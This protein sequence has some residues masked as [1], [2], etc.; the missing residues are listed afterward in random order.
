[1]LSIRQSQKSNSLH[2]LFFRMKNIKNNIFILGLFLWVITPLI[3]LVLLLIYSQIKIS[4]NSIEGGKKIVICFFPL[5]LIIF[6]LSTYIASFE[7]FGDTSIYLDIYYMLRGSDPYALPD[8]GMEPVSFILPKYLSQLTGGNQLS[9]LFVQSLTLNTAFTIYSIIFIPEFYPLV[10]LINIMTQGYYF[11]LFW[12]RQIYSYIFTIPAIYS[13]NIVISSALI[14]VSYF[15]HNSS[16]LFF[17]PT[18]TNFFTNNFT[19]K[20]RLISNKLN[21]SLNIFSKFI[22]IRIM[23]FIIFFLIVASSGFILR[24]SLEFLGSSSLVGETASDKINTYSGNSIADFNQNHFTIRSQLRN[25]LDFIIIFIFAINADYKKINKVFIKWLIL[26]IIMA[27]VYIGSFT[28]GFNL[29]IASIF[30]CLPGFFYTIVFTSG[31]LD[32]RINFYTIVFILSI[33]I[34]SLYFLASLVAPEGGS[35]LVFWGGNPL[36]TPITEYFYL[37]WEFLT[38]GVLNLIPL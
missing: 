7:P 20:L 15:T 5:L 11:Q 9:F 19:N 10:I 37:F 23:F 22:N 34:R 14:Y 29:R 26:F 4:K 8:V 2:Q 16:I 28:F 30:F 27:S 25:I 1:M 32:Y 21:A 6:T 13:S 12:M 36:M 3:G 31:R 18:L 17:I 24:S 33:T 35:Y 38:Q